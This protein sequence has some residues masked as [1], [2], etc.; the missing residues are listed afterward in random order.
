MKIFTLLTIASTAL[1]GASAIVPDSKTQVKFFVDYRIKELPEITNHD[2]AQL[3]NGEQTS[4]EFNVSNNDD[5]DI[6][7]VGVGGSFRDPTNSE[8]KTNLTSAAVTP[9]TLKPGESGTFEQVI[10]VNLI[11]SSYI[12]SPMVYIAINEELRQVQARGQLTTV[13][14]QPVS[15][16]NPQLLFLEFVLL[17]TLGG[18]LYVV[19]SLWGRSYL[20]GNVIPSS[21][22]KKTSSKPTATT[23]ARPL[24]ESWV[25]ESHLKK[26]K[27]RKAY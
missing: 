11:P 4:L 18:V 3:T 14:D 8:V 10:N 5:V 7:V 15:L 9:I 16:L 17:A 6:S 2:V 21:K 25:P 24:D 13:E 1:L 23:T 20:E 27:S 19:Y 22:S 12:L 26:N